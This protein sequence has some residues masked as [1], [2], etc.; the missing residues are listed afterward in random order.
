MFIHIFKYNFKAIL[1]NKDLIFWLLV[2]PLI[3]ITLFNFAF[4]NL[5]KGESFENI[6]IAIIQNEEFNNDNYFKEVINSLDKQENEEGLLNITYITNEDDAK[7][8]LEDDKVI[9]YIIKS[10]DITF[11]IKENGYKQTVMKTILDE[12]ERKSNDVENILK[13]NPSAIAKGLLNDLSNNN[14]FTK[15]ISL[16]KTFPDP[17]VI[18]YYS[19]IGM[20]CMY[21]CFL[22]IR[23]ALA[24]QANLSTLACRIS[25]SPVNKFK[26]FMASMFSAF[27]I[28]MLVLAIVF[29]Y[30]IYLGNINFSNDFIYILLISIVG[31]ICG[32]FFGFF[33]GSVSSKSEDFKITVSVSIVMLL[34]MLSGMMNVQ[35]KYMVDSMSPILKHI[36]PVR[37]ITDALYSLYYYD[38]KDR[39]YGNLI[40]LSIISLIFVIATMML[41]RRK[42]YASL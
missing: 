40:S 4:T 2:F 31:S 6:D 21:A 32:I 7:K 35:T 12:Y 24:V 9:G 29:A 19:Y 36:N 25:M 10:S 13:E 27:C 42:K 34:S 23:N 11:T 8:L 14:E 37:L 26:S 5:L 18:Y 41:I 15:E 22:G 16:G 17:T 33:M 30:M 28:Q 3:L 1:F 39:L 38:S 20:V